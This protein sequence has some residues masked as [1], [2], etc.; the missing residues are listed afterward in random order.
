MGEGNWR[1]NHSVQGPGIAAN[2]LMN[3]SRD[4]QGFCF[5]FLIF[6][7]KNFNIEMNFE[8]NN[9]LSFPGIE[10]I[11]FQLACGMEFKVKIKLSWKMYI[12]DY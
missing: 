5:F 8:T 6:N 7:W 12:V 2:E 10:E 4:S 1:Q 9:L 3:V 11:I